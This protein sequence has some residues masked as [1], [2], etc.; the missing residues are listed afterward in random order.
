M[1]PLLLNPDFCDRTR[2]RKKGG[3]ERWKRPRRRSVKK[4]PGTYEEF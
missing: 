2:R 3:V 1:I 4:K